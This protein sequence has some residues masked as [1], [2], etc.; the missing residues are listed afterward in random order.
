M[1]GVA[2]L[3]A[4]SAVVAFL[5]F[6]PTRRRLQTLE[7]AA[8]SLGDGRSDVHADESGG[9]EVSALSVTFNAMARDLQ[10]RATALVGI[11]PRADVSCWPTSRTS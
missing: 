11:G 7:Q 8:R 5:I 4:G 2:L 9:D 10:A 6:R 3:G 1:L